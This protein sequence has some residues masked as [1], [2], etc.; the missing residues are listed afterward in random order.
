MWPVRPLIDWSAILLKFTIVA[1]RRP[2]I[3]KKSINDLL[4]NDLFQNWLFSLSLSSNIY[5]SGF[6]MGQKVLYSLNFL[7]V[8]Y[9]SLANFVFSLSMYSLNVL[10]FSLSC[11]GIMV[12]RQTLS[13][14]KLKMWDNLRERSLGLLIFFFVVA[15]LSKRFMLISQ[16]NSSDFP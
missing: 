10:N 16:S 6:F 7:P 14:S 9:V 13:L 1:V 11:F 8:L 15:F 2:K 5:S 12:K 4:K 3:N